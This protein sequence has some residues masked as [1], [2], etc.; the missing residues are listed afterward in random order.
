[1]SYRATGPPARPVVILGFECLPTRNY[2]AQAVRERFLPIWLR[3]N[4]SNFMTFST[5]TPHFQPV[6]PTNCEPWRGATSM[7]ATA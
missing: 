7:T 5:P 3:V 6:S 2:L 1:M 4:A